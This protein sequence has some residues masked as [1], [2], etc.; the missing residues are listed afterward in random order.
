MT[1]HPLLTLLDKYAEEVR[2]KLAEAE[3]EELRY[4]PNKM[5]RGFA[6]NRARQVCYREQVKML[7]TIWT[8]VEAAFAHR[9]AR[10]Q[11]SKDDT[12]CYHCKG[13][14]LMYHPAEKEAT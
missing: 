11:G 2:E 1:T 8:Q 5:P 10:S 3:A 6:S 9:E 7:T 12:P 13:S 4:A 14:G